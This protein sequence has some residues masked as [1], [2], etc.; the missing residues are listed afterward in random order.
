MIATRTITN[1][2][3]DFQLLELSKL[4]HRT[5]GRGPF[6]VVQ[7]GCAPDDSSSRNCSFVLTHRGTWLHYYLY[8]ALPEA[9]RR[10]AMFDT[11]ADVF[12]RAETMPARVKVEDAMSLQALL[13]DEGFEPATGDEQGRVL[14]EELKRRHPGEPLPRQELKP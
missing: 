8:L 7:E 13:R 9:V 5:E 12:A 14:F 3:Q 11:V 4:L 1:S 2:Y 6:M 10:V